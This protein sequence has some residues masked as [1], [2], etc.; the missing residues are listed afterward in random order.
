MLHAWTTRLPDGFLEQVMGISRGDV[1]IIKNAGNNVLDRD[2][3]RSVTVTI[4]ALGEEGVMLIEH[5]DCGMASANEEK[6]KV[7]MLEKEIFPKKL[8]KQI[9]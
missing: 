1:K 6:L 5:H 2:I 3:I 8:I 7:T 4:L 9:L